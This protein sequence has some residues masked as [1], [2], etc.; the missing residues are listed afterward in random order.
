MQEPAAMSAE[1]PESAI[2]SLLFKDVI[3]SVGIVLQIYDYQPGFCSYD[4][5]PG[6]VG[7]LAGERSRMGLS[8]ECGTR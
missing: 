5:H 2:N 8:Q 6:L 7:D 3:L 1:A 4:A